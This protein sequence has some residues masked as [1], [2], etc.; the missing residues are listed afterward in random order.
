MKDGAKDKI[1]R[2]SALAIWLDDQFYPWLFKKVYRFF[3]RPSSWRFSLPSNNRLSEVASFAK[4]HHISIR[5]ADRIITAE[6]EEIFNQAEIDCKKR[7]QSL[8]EEAKKA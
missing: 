3:C 7:Y 8:T 5:Q 2:M 6:L 1:K 4:K